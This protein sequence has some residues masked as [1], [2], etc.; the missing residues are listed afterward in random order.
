MQL[1][2]IFVFAYAKCSFF[3]DAAHIVLT[4]SFYLTYSKKEGNL[5][6]VQKSYRGF[7]DNLEESFI[8]SI[9]SYIVYSIGEVLARPFLW[10]HSICLWIPI[11]TAYIRCQI[12]IDMHDILFYGE[13]KWVTSKILS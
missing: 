3:H 5:Q 8:F 2:C 7:S 4:V 10:I 12:L 11:V 6:L 1:I 9:K 13:L